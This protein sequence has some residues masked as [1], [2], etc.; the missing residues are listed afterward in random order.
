MKLELVRIFKD[1]IMVLH[2]AAKTMCVWGQNKNNKLSKLMNGCVFLNFNGCQSGFFIIFFHSVMN[3]YTILTFSSTFQNDSCLLFTESNITRPT[4]FFINFIQ[5]QFAANLNAAITK[6]S[7]LFIS[8][9]WQSPV[10][11][12]HMRWRLFLFC[13]KHWKKKIKL[14]CYLRISSFNLTDVHHTVY[15]TK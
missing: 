4:F 3:S 15:I 13:L 9:N 11:K 6:W 5:N 12:W 2:K 7:P 8:H 1:E 10:F 14:F